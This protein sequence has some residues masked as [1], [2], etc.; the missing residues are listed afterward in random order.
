MSRRRHLEEGLRIRKNVRPGETMPGAVSELDCK[1]SA[2]RL[3]Y[4]RKLCK[5][6]ECLTQ[7]A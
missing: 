5:I 1:E 4:S 3:N 6:L 2:Q 7:S